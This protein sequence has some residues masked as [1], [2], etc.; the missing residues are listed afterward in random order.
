MYGRPID[1]VQHIVRT[2]VILWPIC[3]YNLP[4]SH[5]SASMLSLCVPS[6]TGNALIDKLSFVMSVKLGSALSVCKHGMPHLC[7]LTNSVSVAVCHRGKVAERRGRPAESACGN[8]RYPVLQRPG[9][10]D[11]LG[12]CEYTIHADHYWGPPL[13]Y[14]YRI[15]RSLATLHSAGHISLTRWEE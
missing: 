8:H 7:D 1:I 14:I 3:R 12:H 5:E 9:S 10:T 11:Q 6:Y 15:P 2:H 4:Q 13:H